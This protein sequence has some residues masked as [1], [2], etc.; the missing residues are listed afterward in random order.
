MSRGQ[1]RPLAV[2]P[3]EGHIR[4]LKVLVLKPLTL[5]LKLDLAAG[6]ITVL[7]ARK[8]DVDGS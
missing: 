4:S 5:Y 7:Y 8:R 6:L 2:K 1:L 3:V